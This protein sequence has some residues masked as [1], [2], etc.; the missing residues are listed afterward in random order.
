MRLYDS[1]GRTS[2]KRNIEETLDY[3]DGINNGSKLID[4]NRIYKEEEKKKKKGK[5]GEGR[6]ATYIF[7]A[8]QYLR[9]LCCHPLLVLN[10]KHPDYTAVLQE[11][12]DSL[13]DVSTYSCYEKETMILSQL[14]NAPK[15][16]AL[17]ELLHECGIGVTSAKDKKGKKGKGKDTNNNAS[18]SNSATFSSGNLAGK[19]FTYYACKIIYIYHTC[20]H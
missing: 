13:H 14:S 8:L 5:E 4:T 10:P 9:K 3:E 20:R 15:L 11:M 18:L 1:F 6:G 17:R 19:S 12:K 16:L 2:A 7:Q